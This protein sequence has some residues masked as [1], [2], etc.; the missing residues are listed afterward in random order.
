MKNIWVDYGSMH[1]ERENDARLLALHYVLGN[2]DA[3]Q[4]LGVS[5]SDDATREV[6]TKLLRQAGYPAAVDEAAAAAALSSCKAP[7]TML[8]LGGTALLARGPFSCLAEKVL[9]G[10]EEHLAADTVDFSEAGTVLFQENQTVF[11]TNGKAQQQTTCCCAASTN[12]APDFADLG[13]TAALYI[14]HPEWFAL[15]HQEDG[16]ASYPFVRHTSE[17]L[18]EHVC[19]SLPQMR[20]QEENC[21]C[22]GSYLDKL[23]K[24]AVLVILSDGP[25]HGFQIIQEL[26][27]R[28]L[29]GGESLD[30]TGLYRMLKRM[31][32]AGY[33]VS[34][35]DTEKA[36]AKRVFQIT[37][38]GRSCLENWVDT[39]E[40][41]RDYVD[42][43]V[44]Q[45]KASL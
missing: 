7:V 26:E 18:E 20:M 16:C 23:V 12:D 43:M 32:S 34:R 29:L 36:H 41:Y 22:Q 8:A 37:P 25:S 2:R 39:L 1:I 40:N 28:N 17:A 10:C 9:S 33:L 35:W 21:P 11:I 13:L 14:V 45:I 42:R 44:Q 3:L 31:E 30:A 15:M 38:L 27:R 4:L 6:L 19:K 24:P 5:T